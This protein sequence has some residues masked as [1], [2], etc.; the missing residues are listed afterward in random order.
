MQTVLLGIGN[1]LQGDDGI[2]VFACAYLKAN[3]LFPENVSIIE[4]GV[5][6]INLVNLFLEND[7]I[8]I[9]DAIEI[10]DAPGSIYNIPA[11]E[12]SGYGLANGGAHEVGV[13]Q[14]LDIVELMGKELP[15]SHLLGIVPQRIDLNIGLSAELE[16]AF[17]HYLDAVLSHLKQYHIA[18]EPS[19]RLVSLD[20]IIESYSRPHQWVEK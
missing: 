15:I 2:G 6:G 19:D 16:Q 10:D 9:L 17:R 4:G 18:V 5:E 14:C 13:L 11:C 8:I 1:I 20:R 7:H 12:L 3:Y